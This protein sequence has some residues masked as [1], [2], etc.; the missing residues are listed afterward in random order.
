[1]FIKVKQYNTVKKHFVEEQK[2]KSSYAT[3]KKMFAANNAR[4]V[5]A[6]LQKGQFADSRKT[7][8]AATKVTVCGQQEAM[9]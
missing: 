7:R 8:G 4:H 1:M 5:S 9:L 2:Q 6:I 3:D